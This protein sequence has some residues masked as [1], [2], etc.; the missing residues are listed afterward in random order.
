MIFVDKAGW[1]SEQPAV[2]GQSF[3]YTCRYVF[4]FSDDIFRFIKRL[5]YI[6]DLYKVLND[7]MNV[8]FRVIKEG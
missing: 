5:L 1:L 6:R 2:A 7:M 4:M 3:K 8:Y